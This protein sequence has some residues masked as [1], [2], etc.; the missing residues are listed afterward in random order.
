MID[1]RLRHPL[2]LRRAPGRVLEAAMREGIAPSFESIEGWVFRG[3]NTLWLT[4]LFGFQ[5]FAKGFYRG[6]ER[7]CGPSPFLQGYNVV[8]AQNGNW[9]THQPRPSEARPRLH[10]YYRVYQAPNRYANAL[11]LDYAKGAN[12]LNPAGLLRDYLV[13]P[14]PDEPDLLLGKA[15]V[16]LGVWVPVSFFVLQ[17][18]RAGWAT[19]SRSGPSS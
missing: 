10:G 2:A 1:P 12:G 5:K 19:D 11:F 8:V 6:A 3:W 4:R 15:Y 16:A 18:W 7:A 9:D 13:Q 14:W 17:R